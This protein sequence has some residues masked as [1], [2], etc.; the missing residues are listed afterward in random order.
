MQKIINDGFAGSIEVFTEHICCDVSG[1]LYIVKVHTPI[2]SIGEI[3]L[4]KQWLDKVEPK[5]YE[6]F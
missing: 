1:L 5:I 2:Q 4:E 3:V 6:G